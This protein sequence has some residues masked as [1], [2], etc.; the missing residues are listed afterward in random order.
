MGAEIRLKFSTTRCNGT[1]LEITNRD[2]LKQF[3]KVAFQRY[4]IELFQLYEP[5]GEGEGYF[6]VKG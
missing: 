6:L 4:V 1:I 3:Y 5:V 2:S